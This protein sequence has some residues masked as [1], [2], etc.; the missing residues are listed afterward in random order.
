MAIYF[1]ASQ[2]AGKG[3][4]GGYVE[5][6]LKHWKGKL[7]VHKSSL[8]VYR[9][10]NRLVAFFART[11]GN[12]GESGSGWLVFTW[13]RPA[14]NLVYRLRHGGWDRKLSEGGAHPPFPETG[15]NWHRT[16]C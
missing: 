8:P 1:E 3:G 4:R 12:N 14:R 6:S 7:V 10:L 9:P 15:S 5:S 16:N 11:A 13:A 2:M